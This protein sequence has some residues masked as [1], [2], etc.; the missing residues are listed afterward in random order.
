[1]GRAGSDVRF[2]VAGAINDFLS[3]TA[4]G[5][6]AI[7]TLG[8]TALWLGGTQVPQAKITSTGFNTFGTGVLQQGA[9]L[10]KPATDGDVMTVRNAAGTVVFDVNTT[11]SAAGSQF[12]FVNGASLIGYTDNFSTQSFRIIG[13]T[14]QAIFRSTSIAPATDGSAIFTLANSASANVFQINTNATV[15]N[16][17]V[18]VNNGVVLAGNSDAGAT[19]KWSL[20]SAN[21]TFKQA[22]TVVASLPS[23]ATVGSG[24]RHFVTDATVTVT[25]GIGAT[26]AGG[27][28]NFAPV[29]SDG[30]NWKI[31]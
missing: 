8:A 16:S 19:V 12:E 31:G 25:A 23:A 11:V 6:A 1:M 29:Y 13:S 14:G 26:V 24:A 4:V 20:N 3:G 18:A 28:S 9:V 5:D 27:G 22:A 10:I 2:G 30:T 15:G 17:T 21:G 7:F